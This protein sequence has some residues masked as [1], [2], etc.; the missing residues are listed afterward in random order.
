MAQWPAPDYHAADRRRDRDRDRRGQQQWSYGQGGGGAPHNPYE[1]RM[2]RF[3]EFVAETQ[4]PEDASILVVDHRDERLVSPFQTWLVS[5]IMSNSASSINVLTERDQVM[6][7]SGGFHLSLFANYTLDGVKAVLAIAVESETGHTCAHWDGWTAEALAHPA[8]QPFTWPMLRD[9]SASYVDVKVFNGNELLFHWILRGYRSDTDLTVQTQY[10]DET[11]IREAR[12]GNPRLSVVVAVFIGWRVSILSFECGGRTYS[13]GPRGRVVAGD[14]ARSRFELRVTSR[15][16]EDAYGNDAD[17][18]EFR[19]RDSNNRMDLKCSRTSVPGTWLTVSHISGPTLVNTIQSVRQQR[20]RVEGPEQ[21]EQF[22]QLA[23]IHQGW[24][25]GSVAGSEA[26]VGSLVIFVG[27]MAPGNFHVQARSKFMRREPVIVA[28]E[29]LAQMNHAPDTEIRAPQG[30]P[31]LTADAWA[32]G[33]VPAAQAIE[34][35]R[36]EQLALAGRRAGAE[37]AHRTLTR[38]EEAGMHG[39]QD[40]PERDR[41]RL[42]RRFSRS[43]AGLTPGIFADEMSRRIYN[44]TTATIEEV[45]PVTPRTS[46]P[47]APMKVP[48]SQPTTDL[49]G[50]ARS[51]AEVTLESPGSAPVSLGPKQH[52]APE[53]SAEDKKKVEDV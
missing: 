39:H 36:E 14:S 25:E 17:R 30:P 23:A 6:P 19:F 7:P 38:V 48:M 50:P 34:G 40:D 47:E 51:S 5:E 32:E 24:W 16:T 52:P 44:R 11:L 29:A 9:T 18:I 2:A 13:V 49:G 3:L 33:V 22:A 53:I 43:T 35:D 12:L 27:N 37:M 4:D 10:V 8:F 20:A 28:G 26:E 31:A 41:A 45:D 1:V 46:R 21:T 42:D 15:D